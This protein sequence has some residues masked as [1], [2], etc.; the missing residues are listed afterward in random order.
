M[1]VSELIGKLVELKGS[2]G[3]ADVA[4]QETGS[5]RCRYDIELAVGR[6]GPTEKVFE[7]RA[8]IIAIL[9]LSGNGGKRT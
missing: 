2:L 3:D 7:R 6:R 8:E 9:R 5:N 4:I 1:K